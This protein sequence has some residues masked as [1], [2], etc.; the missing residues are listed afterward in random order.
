MKDCIRQSSHLAIQI[1]A[2]IEC[3]P[4]CHVDC[5]RK[6]FGPKTILWTYAQSCLKKRRSLGMLV[7]C[8][9]LLQK[10]ENLVRKKPLKTHTFQ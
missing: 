1:M 10:A 3:D 9:E 2:I 7:T 6:N 4:V 5:Q 8:L